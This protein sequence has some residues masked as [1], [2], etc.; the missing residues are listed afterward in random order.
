MSYDYSE[1]ILFK[2][3]P[4]ICSVMNWDGMSGLLTIEKS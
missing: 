4:V 3:V 2:K 1:N